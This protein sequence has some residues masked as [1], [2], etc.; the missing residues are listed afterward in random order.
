[1]G[2][3]F[4]GGKL[5]MDSFEK[6]RSF[7]VNPGRFC[8]VVLGSRGVGKHFAIQC[9]F[10][11]LLDIT[12]ISKSLKTL[13]FID[14]IEIPENSDDLDRL[15]SINENGILVIEDIENLS[16]E[17]QHLLFKALSTTNGMFGIKKKYDIR[18]VFTSCLEIETL[19]ESDSVLRGLFWD[20]I[21]QLIVEFPNFKTE[22]SN[23]LNDFKAIWEK[24][25]FEDIVEYKAISAYPFNTKIQK[26]IQDSADKFE[27]GFRDLDKIACMYY[28]YRIY[29]YREK[30]KI[31][32]E[33][34]INI[35]DQ[36]K[37]DFLGKAQLHSNPTNDLSVF[38]I[39]PGY[40]MDELNA[41]FRI[42]VRKWAKKEYGTL[43][44]AATKLEL[45][46]STLKNYVEG[47]ATFNQRNTKNKK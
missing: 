13:S 18:I 32:E 12:S 37:N 22:N 7:L 28:N 42:Q 31:L 3:K 4:T 45:S 1:M 16:D 10:D 24:M 44:K 26:F 5:R 46:Q 14:S 30:K 8:L 27:G 40:T 36:V 33:T 41:Q 29:Y 25:K 43:H 21:S 39:N 47:K 35:V 2:H 19:R 11:E 15:L 20:R 34:E 9:A 38:Q 6:L 17:Q 23:I